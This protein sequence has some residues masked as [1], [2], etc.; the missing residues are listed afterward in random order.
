[1]SNF[2][3]SNDPEADFYEP[4]PAR[5]PIREAVMSEPVGTGE[6]RA[7]YLERLGRLSQQIERE[8]GIRARLAR[9]APDILD[10]ASDAVVLIE[11]F[12]RREPIAYLRDLDGTGSLHPCSKE[13]PGAIPVFDDEHERNASFELVSRAKQTIQRAS[14]ESA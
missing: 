9:S 3:D 2:G 1:M 12:C 7:E 6:T 13:D 14:G 5:Q 4:L 10:V 8:R 11:A